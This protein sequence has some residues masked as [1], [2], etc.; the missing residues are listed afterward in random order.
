MKADR[1]RAEPERVSIYDARFSTNGPSVLNSGNDGDD[2]N[3]AK[4]FEEV[5]HN[6]PTTSDV[7]SS[8]I[9]VNEFF[10]GRHSHRSV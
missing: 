5:R 9:G 3:R 10:V 1:D 4:E 8:G 6:F 2:N 7:A